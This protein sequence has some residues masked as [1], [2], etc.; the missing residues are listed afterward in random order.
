MIDRMIESPEERGK[1]A[2][3][4]RELGINE[5]TAQRWWKQYQET[6]EVPYK[7]SR[8]NG[9]ES[10]FKSE[11]QEYV[12]K[13]LDED[14]QLYSVDI[15][16]KLAEQFMGF[17]IS[18]AQLNHHLKNTMLIT[19]KK[20][21]F[22]PAAR[23]SEANLQAR[24]NWYMEWKDT[25]LDF[26]KNCVFIDESGFHINM[27]NNW[28]RSTV[29][30]PAI[31][32][33][34]RTRSPSHTIIGAIHCSSVI[35]VSLKKPPPKKDRVKKDDSTVAQK[36]RIVNK[37]KKRTADEFIMEEPNIE[38]VDIVDATAR[39]SAAP[40]AKGTTTGHF[41][42]FMNEVLDIMDQDESLKGHYLVMDNC[43]IHKSKPMIRKIKSRGYRVMYLPPYS[44]ELNSIEQFWN[45][46]KGKL[47]RDR[48]M[49]DENLS[50]R[51][52]DACNDIP[53]EVLYNFCIYSKKQI[54][55][56]YTKTPF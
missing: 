38:Y 43:T 23:N 14:P 29:G 10:S 37:G 41:I 21:T 51:I 4:A 12:R 16:D 18:K 3:F 52:G 7:K 45:T 25:D 31:V 48:L 35:H 19:V 1:A 2:R 49:N 9:L 50:S 55:K 34:P 11:H 6:N 24:Y 20:P 8:A 56:C 5:R 39:T 33:T 32:K 28:A 42:K 47:K 17:S 36:K 40:V 27:R 30:T 44:P 46:A 53:V 54:I 13:L 15:I 22:E 26:A